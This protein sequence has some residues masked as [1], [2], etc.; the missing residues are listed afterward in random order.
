MGKTLTLTEKELEVLPLLDHSL[1]KFIRY[2]GERALTGLETLE[3]NLE[4]AAEENLVKWRPL[5]FFF[6]AA[7]RD[8]G[9]LEMSFFIDGVDDTHGERLILDH[10]ISH[11]LCEILYLFFGGLFVFSAL[12]HWF[13]KE[14]DKN[15][16]NKR[17]ALIWTQKLI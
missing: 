17:H 3:R 5:F 8:S 15:M 16:K 14:L 11:F 1:R 2:V 9:L 12:S 10:H 4:K 7:L 6:F 13:S